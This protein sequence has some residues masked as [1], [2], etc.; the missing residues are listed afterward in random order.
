MR[1]GRGAFLERAG[2]VP[3][4]AVVGAGQMAQKVYLPVLAALEDVELA[5]L[6]EPRRSFEKLLDT[7][8]SADRMLTILEQG[9]Y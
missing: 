7:S 5:V 2:R 4:V 8:R 6:V 9:V 3:R 1:A